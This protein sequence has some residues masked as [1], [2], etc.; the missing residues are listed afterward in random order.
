V[1]C[2][3][4]RVTEDPLWRVLSIPRPELPDHDVG[5]GWYRKLRQRLGSGQRFVHCLA[6]HTKTPVYRVYTMT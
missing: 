5:P 1:P 4:S 6:T 2:Q 3:S